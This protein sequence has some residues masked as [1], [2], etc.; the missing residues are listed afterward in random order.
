MRSVDRLALVLAVSSLA[1]CGDYSNDDLR[2]LAALPRHAD[3]AVAVPAQGGGTAA[4]A[5]CTIGSAN[6]WLQA[7]P[8]SDGLNAIADKVIGFID[9]VR[10]RE[11][12]RRADDRREWGP[13]DDG[14][15]PGIEIIV[16]MQR[17]DGNAG[18]PA[19]YDYVFGA[20]TKGG[21]WWTPVLVGTFVGG[22]ASTGT[23]HATLDFDAIRALGMNDASTPTGSLQIGYDRASEPRATALTLA[24]GGFGL[25]RFDYVFFGY[26]DGSGRFW[27]RFRNAAGDTF[28]VDAGFDAA[29]AGR[30]EVGFVAAG[31]ATGSFRQCWDALACLDYVDDPGNYSCDPTA[32]PCNKGSLAACPAVP[33]AAF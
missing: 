8:T 13:F 32:W 23:G 6:V 20:R 30:G 29:G 21:A 19:R 16:V 27:Y 10:G 11:P 26:A 5:A 17:I 12:T 7:K 24:G 15:H 14:Q 2:F 22:S 1:A 33:S 9:V 25:E 31:G 3:V 4:L 18:A 28:T